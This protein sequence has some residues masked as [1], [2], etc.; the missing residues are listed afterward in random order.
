MWE[1]AAG[2]LV[3]SPA[4]LLHIPV[5]VEGTEVSLLSE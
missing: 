1:A 4:K 3:L 5:G 2:Q